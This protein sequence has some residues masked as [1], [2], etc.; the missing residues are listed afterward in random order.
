MLTDAMRYR[1]S[2]K[3]EASLVESRPDVCSRMRTY[4]HVCSRMLIRIRILLYM[5]PHATVC[6]TSYYL[7]N[8]MRQDTSGS[9]LSHYY[10]RV[11]ILLYMCP[12]ATVCVSSYYLTTA[13]AT[14]RA[15]APCRTTTCVSSYYY[16]CVV[17]LLYMCPRTT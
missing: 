6:V 3:T 8:S 15:E 5:C 10:I 4:A 7:T 9:P 16:V 14:I 11:R 2:A 17:M 1:M 12:H 13:C